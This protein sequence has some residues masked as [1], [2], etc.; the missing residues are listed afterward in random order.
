MKEVE[1][2]GS[3]DAP[4]AE[5]EPELTFITSWALSFR[6]PFDVAQMSP[7]PSFKP[8]LKDRLPKT[9]RTFAPFALHTAPSVAPVSWL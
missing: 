2:N 8:R 1:G 7:R 4:R 9:S 3:V 5:E 6:R